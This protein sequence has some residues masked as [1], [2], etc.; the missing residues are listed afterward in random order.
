MDFQ[1]VIRGDASQYSAPPD[2]N[3]AIGPN[4]FV[5]T[6]N[7][8]FAV[9]EKGTGTELVS[10]SLGAFLPGSS[11][12]PRVLFDQHSGR[13]VVIVSDLNSKIYLAV[14]TTDDPTGSWF[15]TDF[16]VSLG[17]DSGTWP[18]YPTLG[19]DQYGIYTAAYMVGAGMSIFAIDKAPLIAPSPSLG[20]V[21]AFRGLPWEGAI[22]PAH[23]YGS[24]GG[25][26]LI[27]RSGSTSLRLR[28]IN[29]PLTSPTLTEMGFVSIPS[30]SY[31][32][33][34]PALGSSTPLDTVDYRPMNA[35]YRNGSLW[36][37]H[38]ISY[39]GRAAC[40]WYE[41]DPLTVSTVQVG[42]V[43][44]GSLYYFFPSIAVN[45]FGRVVLGFSG[46][47]ASQYASAYYTGR[48]PTD[49]PGQMAPPALL[50]AGTAAQNIIDSY[51]RNRFGDYSYTTLDPVDDLS[52]WTIQEYVHA[53]DIWG[54]WIG[55]LASADCNGNGID[56]REDILAGTSLDCNSNNVPDECEPNADCNGNS[57][58]DI[59]DIAAGTS[60]DCNNNKIPDECD[61]AAGTSADANAN[62]VPDECEA[63]VLYVDAAA[64]GMNRGTTWGDA[65]TDLQ[66]ALDI[67][68]LPGSS[69]T[70]IW[71]KAGT[72]RPSA[73]SSPSDPRTATFKLPEGVS[74]L[75]GFAGGETDPSQRDPSV[76]TTVISGDLAQNDGAGDFSE[77]SYHPVLAT[78][79]S[80]APVLDGFTITAGYADGLDTT[81][82][83]GGLYV[84][85]TTLGAAPLV[86]NCVFEGNYA[87]S[88]GGAVFTSG[89]VGPTLSRCTIVNNSCGTKGAGVCITQGS[90]TL[91]D[92]L[93]LGNS[94]A[95]RG[96]GVYVGSDTASLAMINCV[97]SGNFAASGG[98]L[99][100][101]GLT[102]VSGCAFSGNSASSSGGGIYNFRAFSD[103]AV[104]NSI[105]WGNS[106]AGGM[107]ESAQIHVANGTT[108]IT[109][110]C[111][112]GW[113]TPGVDGNID[114][115]PQFVNALGGDGTAGTLDD[116]LRLLDVSPC[117]DAGDNAAVPPGVTADLDGKQRI[118]DGDGD[119]T[120]DV[121]MGAY[122]FSPPSAGCICG[123]IDSSGGAVDLNDFNSFSLCF[124]LAG[125]GGDCAAE[126]FACSDLDGTGDVT[127]N[128]FGTFA[129][130][131][132]GTTA[133]QVPNCLN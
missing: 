76:N 27:S 95:S 57:V 110:N 118:I 55:V 60:T 88:R 5:E 7:R 68:S 39:N 82:S 84:D 85:V 40:R 24:P 16:T 132:G 97:L 92:C 103:L 96:G 80:S 104:V 65:Y 75:G 12:D 123:D 72:Y 11:G 25:E 35:V 93:I 3:G 14:S 59:C 8:V 90:L 125:P 98:G 4:H 124:G 69:V 129:I 102:T 18:D 109:S 64:V 107:D 45:Q 50:H 77:N 99:A 36:T 31:P 115:D 111:I 15:K 26:Y 53:D 113:S 38:C 127:L 116:D 117:I 33:D 21:T 13:W 89:T 105:L 37:T 79:L 1:G 126:A 91:I 2:T 62:T 51:G 6:V 48:M 10:I 66:S 41:I 28:R 9:Y 71:V 114:L 100:T 49:P 30:H 106:D 122:E 58:Q 34:A 94:A 87:V 101:R 20:T 32:P 119:G 131:F 29:P 67:A 56:D 46:S 78:G 19:A 44:D 63:A 23:T 83:G 61:I 47:N 74:V 120:A 133:N 70:Q 17:S 121:D 86:S 22:Q 108:T 54:T 52:I 128:D 81:G 112:Q 73:P 43:S 42:T 130:L